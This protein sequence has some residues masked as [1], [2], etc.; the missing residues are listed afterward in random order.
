[1]KEELPDALIVLVKEVSFDNEL[2]REALGR[3]A[4]AEADAL[5]DDECERRCVT[6]GPGG[7]VISWVS[8][9]VSLVMVLVGMSATV[10][11]GVPLADGD[12]DE[13]LV[14]L[15]SSVGV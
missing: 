5:G 8:V 4:V 2:V 14:A 1:M 9:S 15:I 7:T 13:V 6:E 11:V 3:S 10:L 12:P